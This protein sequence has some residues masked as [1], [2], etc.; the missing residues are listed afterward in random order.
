[1]GWRELSYWL[2]GGIILFVITPFVFLIPLVAFPC[3]AECPSF[4]YQITID[5]LFLP[6][7]I[8]PDSLLNLS[9]L[10]L[11][12]IFYSIIGFVAGILIGL[13]YGKMKSR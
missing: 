2:R 4:I 6:N 3:G 8:F 7:S 10:L 11:P 5:L 12:M 13:L 1:M 9:F